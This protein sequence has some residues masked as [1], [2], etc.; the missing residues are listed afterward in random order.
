MS[1]TPLTIRYDAGTL[2]LDGVDE[3]FQPPSA[4]QWDARV[5]RWRAPAMAYRQAIREL[6]RS[7]IAHE[8][9]AR[10][11]NDFKSNPSNNGKLQ[12][13]AASS[14]CRLAQAKA[15]WRKWRL[16]SRSA[17]RSSSCRRWI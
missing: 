13:D 4:F 3:T 10:N 16:N 8:D 1:Q 11:Y 5:R 17:K 6:T 15:S 2:V 7:D 12:A 9:Q 14:C